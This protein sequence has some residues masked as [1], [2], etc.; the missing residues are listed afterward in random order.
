MTVRHTERPDA[1]DHKSLALWAADC[2]ER[3]LPFFE[4]ILPED[5]RPRNAIEAARA[6]ARGE[7]PMTKA[8]EAAFAAHAAARNTNIEP[9]RLAARATGH[10]AATAHVADHARYAANYAVKAVTAASADTA[11]IETERDWQYR[12]IP[13][14]LRSVAI[15]A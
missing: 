15:R 1:K 2:A 5:D 13:E 4:D 3:V 7:L 14:H 9:A 12:R 6:W 10:A 8:R 11:A